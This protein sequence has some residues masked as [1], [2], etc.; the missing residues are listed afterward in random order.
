MK[1]K[2][3]ISCLL[4]G[5]LVFGFAGLANAVTHKA[6]LT[7]TIKFSPATAGIV[8]GGTVV[9]K[10]TSSSGL[11]VTLS[12]DATTTQYCSFNQASG[13]VT[14]L[15][16][17]TCKIKAAQAGNA[18]Y[19]ATTAVLSI[20]VKQ[21]SQ[22]ISFGA[23]PKITVP[24]G[25]GTVTASASSGLPVTFASKT[26][27]ICSIS[28]STVTG[29]KAGICTISADQAGNATYAPATE[30]SQSFN[31]TQQVATGG[32][33][34]PVTAPFNCGTLASSGNAVD[35]GRRAYNRLNCVSC[36]GQDGSGGMGPDIRGEADGV[37]E[38]VY[39]EGA[40][41]SFAGFLCPNDIAD[42]QAYIGSISKAVKYLDWDIQFQKIKDGAIAPT[43]TNVVVGP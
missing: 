41:P 19:A 28:G 35:D 7:Q 13:L 11:S 43:P 3:C 31:I 16:A 14:G 2:T 4:A 38:A 18:A 1:F 33:K 8:V 24:G 29:L 32:S 36:H 40:M 26:L 30:V 23:A 12:Q 9:V 25:T 27:T 17:G 15:G 37:S 6:L 22:T 21:T 39:G 20:S 34:L 42:L 10:A 5:I